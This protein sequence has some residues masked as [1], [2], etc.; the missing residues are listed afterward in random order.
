MTLSDADQQQRRPSVAK[1]GP[2]VAPRATEIVRV[3]AGAPGHREHEDDERQIDREVP[4]GRDHRRPDCDPRGEPSDQQRQRPLCGHAQSVALSAS[5]NRS[6]SAV[7]SS[8][9]PDGATTP[10]HAAA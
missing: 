10:A 5:V 2:D 9:H 8:V 3:E 1:T 4:T 7:S 6:S